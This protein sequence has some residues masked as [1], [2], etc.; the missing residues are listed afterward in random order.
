LSSRD[1]RFRGS[2]QQPLYWSG[3][4]V[5]AGRLPASDAAALARRSRRCS[6]AGLRSRPLR[7]AGQA[8]RWA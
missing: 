8:L 2:R 4:L 7:P 5:L 6:P 3:A 1:E